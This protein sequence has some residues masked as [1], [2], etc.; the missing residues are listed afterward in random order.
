MTINTAPDHLTLSFTRN[1]AL[2][3]TEAMKNAG[4]R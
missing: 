4:F 1:Q 2:E 3:D